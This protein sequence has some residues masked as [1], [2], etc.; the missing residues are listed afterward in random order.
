MRF[1]VFAVVCL[2]AALPA[3]AQFWT[4]PGAKSETPTCCTG[5]RDAAEGLLTWQYE[6]PIVA[7][8]GRYVDSTRIGIYQNPFRTARARRIRVNRDWNR[9]YIALGEAI[10]A[11]PLDT[12]FTTELR[13]PMETPNSLALS[14][15]PTRNPI[16]SIAVPERYFYAESPLS[17][18]ICGSPDAGDVLTDFDSDDRGNL[19]VG[20]IQ[21]GWGFAH[22][23]H[24]IPG[25]PSYRGMMDYRVQ[26]ASSIEPTSVIS[27]KI[28]RMYYAVISQHVASAGATM[29]Y[30]VTNDKTTPR[31]IASRPGA[32][33][34]RNDKYGI[35]AW[36]KYEEGQRLALLN[37]DGHVRIY[38]Y[39]EFIADAEPLADFT[40]ASGKKFVSLAF[41]DEGKLW[42]AETSQDVDRNHLYRV[43]AIDG[44][45]TK[46]AFDV[47][48]G[49]FSPTVLHVGGGYVAVAGRSPADPLERSGD[50]RLLRITNGEP[51]PVSD[52]GFFRNYYD[53]APSGYATPR[54]YTNPYI[55]LR[56]LQLVDQ[57]S[58]TYLMYSTLGLGDV[59]ELSR[60][61]NRIPTTIALR[62]ESNG[63][64][65]QLIA[66]V[67][68]SSMGAAPLSGVVT[69]TKNG[70]PLTNA[71]VSGTNDPL[72]FIVNLPRTDLT[73][74]ATLGAAYEGD[75]LYAPSGPV[76][77]QFSPAALAA[78]TGF[79][80]IATTA[81]SVQLTWDA[82]PG[83][84]LYEVQRRG[85]GG[86][87]SVLATTI[88]PLYLD[89]TVA[90]NQVY[91]Y[92]V[93]A[94]GTTAG[95][96][97]V[98]ELASTY[99]L[100]D[101]PL[102]EGAVVQAAHV[103]ELR[104]IVNAAR[105]VAGMAPFAFTDAGLA[106]GAVIR[107]VHAS[108]LRTACEQLRAELGLA[109]LAPAAAFS[110]ADLLTLRAGL[111]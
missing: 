17:G 82:V 47:Y 100:T 33:D 65:V 80:A 92:R 25:H 73:V 30:D 83:V 76:S 21:F 108:E 103:T 102:H 91:L 96:D 28:G 41:D 52:R 40:P 50:M 23:G 5:C 85:S 90:A 11:Y 61:E 4:F 59:Y 9:V 107:A 14:Q 111:R 3:P 22:D 110:R 51:V 35:A 93:H 63:P 67:T 98:T 88:A 46:E 16:E 58:K 37:T 19:Y 66:T 104:T 71:N 27:L 12:F 84:V 13:K 6:W 42:L 75:D 81:A 53:I 10:A 55:G 18:W 69:I 94:V 24:V 60:G 7:H 39:A 8:T 49:P 78:P 56:S 70:Q 68:A 97:S 38:D 20:T 89:L 26:V 101:D 48:G 15:H 79:H 29:L 36:A 72:T 45:Y 62:T 105:A 77:I 43:T 44:G 74:A 109:P 32:D 57:G 99:A 87:W 86:P 106:P 1:I 64:N 54:I 34:E 2:L 95:P 31:E